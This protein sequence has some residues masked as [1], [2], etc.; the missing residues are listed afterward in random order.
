[1]QIAG[2]HDR[3]GTIELSVRYP[4]FAVEGYLARGS[5]AVG[6]LLTLFLPDTT[7][8]LQADITAFNLLV[9]PLLVTSPAGLLTTDWPMT[10]SR[11][12]PSSESAAS[13]SVR[14]LVVNTDGLTTNHCT[15]GPDGHPLEKRDAA[16]LVAVETS[17][18]RR[19][20][21]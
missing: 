5:I 1:M 8:P 7:L 2:Y 17:G 14:G 21:V 18:K 15:I 6:D 19:V 13:I 3:Q 12:C 20:A 10:I 11:R 4:D 9:T 16:G